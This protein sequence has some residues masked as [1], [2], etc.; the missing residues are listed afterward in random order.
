M[1]YDA[2]QQAVVVRF[3]AVRS[4]RDGV[5]ET[6]RFESVVPGVSGKPAPVAAALNRAANAVAADVAAWIG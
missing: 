4:T 6:R 1:G 3:E 5:I 2:A